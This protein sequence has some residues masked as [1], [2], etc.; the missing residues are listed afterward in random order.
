MDPQITEELLKA[1]PDICFDC[2]TPDGM[3]STVGTE[4]AA[5][6]KDSPIKRIVMR[7]MRARGGYHEEQYFDQPISN[8]LCI[9]ELSRDLARAKGILRLILPSVDRVVNTAQSVRCRRG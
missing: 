7:H 5:E 3:Y 6:K 4:W 2:S 8:M 1:F 9:D